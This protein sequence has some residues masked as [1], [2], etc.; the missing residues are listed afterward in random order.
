[1]LVVIPARM[2][3]R[4]LPRK[5]LAS[6]GGLPLVEHVRRRAC[7]AAS[8]ERVLVA[9]D[10]PRVAE[11][12]RSH[13]GEAVLTGPAPS[14]TH[15]VALAAADHTGPVINVQ[16]DMPLLDPHHVDRVAYLLAAGAEVAT[17]SAPWPLD[18]PQEDPALVKVLPG[19]D[20]QRAPAPGARLH[21]GIY[22]FGPGV[23]PRAASAPRS[24]RA[25]AEDLEQLAWL[26]AGL[27][28][29]VGEVDRAPPSVDTP[30]QLES[31]RRLVECVGEGFGRDSDGIGAE[32]V[33]WG[34]GTG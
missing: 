23:L 18:A 34:E 19:P 15:R 27:A 25:L 14:G 28:I 26:D 33:S 7:M 29:R 2:G 6:I 30:E 32:Q 12:V 1:M 31:V 22:G 10:D 17:L 21:V 20:F 8:A 16:A 11:V 4:R 13:G 3:S 9:T 24:A 5:V